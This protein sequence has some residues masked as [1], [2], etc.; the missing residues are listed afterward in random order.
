MADYRLYAFGE[1][2]NSY[3]AALMLALT[4]SDWERVPV[5]YFNGQTR[6]AGFRETVNEMGEA[7][8]LLHKGRT[9]TQSGVILDYLAAETGQF[10][11]RD[12]DERREIL[13]WILFDNHKF[14]S[15][16]ATLRFLV[17]LQKSGESPVTAFLRG[18]AAGAFAIVDKHLAGRDFMVGGRP[19]IADISL[20]GYIF[21]DEETG[22]ALAD[23]P[24][25]LAWRARIAALP[26]W[27]PPYDL[28]PPALPARH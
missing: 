22:M 11:P 25:I 9:L 8:V 6:T 19:T 14:T 15:Y 3:K 7:P 17:G 16:Y 13:R 24:H 28:V 12:E 5:D 10:G 23:Y 4:G 27:K 1:S 21:F 2:G 20:A 18:R 26:G